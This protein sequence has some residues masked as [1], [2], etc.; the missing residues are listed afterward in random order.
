MSNISINSAL[1][2]IENKIKSVLYVQND[3]NDSEYLD[4][5]YVYH[6]DDDRKHFRYYE[7]YSKD[8]TCSL[9]KMSDLVEI[10]KCILTPPED[11]TQFSKKYD[12][13]CSVCRSKFNISNLFK[14][15][16]NFDDED[17]EYYEEQCVLF[18]TSHFN[19][20]K[21]KCN[22][23][24]I[25]PFIASNEAKEEINHYFKLVRLFNSFFNE[26]NPYFDLEE[27]KENL[28]KYLSLL[29]EYNDKY[30]H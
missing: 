14:M 4:Q 12:K 26:L 16:S 2:E 8:G 29:K 5:M 18:L 24:E 23:D 13:I 27:F 3:L 30:T 28:N 21:F 22:S 7:V 15:N 10:L 25:K 11:S 20:C 19:D 6:S 9:L 1:T 17:K